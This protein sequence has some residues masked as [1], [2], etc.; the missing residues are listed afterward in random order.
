MDDKVQMLTKNVDHLRQEVS[1]K[2]ETIKKL[3]DVIDKTVKPKG[4]DETDEYNN[5]VAEYK[6]QITEENLEKQRKNITTRR[7]SKRNKPEE[8]EIGDTAQSIVNQPSAQPFDEITFL[9]DEIRNKNKIIEFL[10]GRNTVDPTYRFIIDEEED[11]DLEE[12]ETVPIPMDD[13]SMMH[14]RTLEIMERLFIEE[15]QPTESTLHSIHETEIEFTQQSIDSLEEDV[16]ITNETVDGTEE[17]LMALVEER[18]SNEEHINQ[19]M[20]K[21]EQMILQINKDDEMLSVAPWDKH[22]NGFASSYMKKNG[23]QP[24][25]GLGKTGSGITEPISSEKKTLDAG[26]TN[27]VTW[28]KGTILVAGASMIGGL[29]EKKM[30]R[31]GR[32]KVRSHGGATILDMRDHLNAI[33]RKKP[34]HLV[35]HV[36]S[37][38]A[39]NKDTSA[40][41]MFDQLMDLKAF[42]EDKVANIKVTLS[43]PIVRT[44]NN[45]A[46]AK[47]IQLKNR[48]KRSGL[49][50]IVNDDIE[51]DD[52][53]RKGL[54]LKNS[55]TRKLA[56][57][58]IDYLKSV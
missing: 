45:L 31:T 41:D 1:E 32:V 10:T 28:P 22:S 34:D 33:L 26:A 50:V 46:N 19:R 21:I 43:L 6:D 37:N 27:S 20:D 5:S 15:M 17:R 48:L 40:D 24:G 4:L 57:N 13:D 36:H 35:L 52:L 42:A 11:D 7:R 51:K 8:T 2:N 39:Q 55:G 29:E 23:H 30:S 47:Q 12:Q 54:H 38:D 25:K 9:R 14:D 53:A 3:I 16:I 56:K 44:D 58:I 49:E 18:K